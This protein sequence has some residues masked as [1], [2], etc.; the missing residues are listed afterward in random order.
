M[1]PERHQERQLNDRFQSLS[2]DDISD[3]PSFAVLWLMGAPASRRSWNHSHSCS[4]YSIEDFNRFIAFHR[5]GIASLPACAKS[6][7]PSVH[8]RHGSLHLSIHFL[9]LLLFLR[10]C[11]CECHRSLKNRSL[12]RSSSSSSILQETWES[13]NSRNEAANTLSKS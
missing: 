13:S 1:I 8:L 11:F 7:F 2:F 6:V 12:A 9:V 3:S 5:I 10:N 4:F